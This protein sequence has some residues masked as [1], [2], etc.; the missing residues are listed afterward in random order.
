M[1]ENEGGEV[2]RERFGAKPYR[3]GQYGIGLY[4]SGSTIRIEVVYNYCSVKSID[5]LQTMVPKDGSG[6]IH[7]SLNTVC[8]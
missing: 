1:E 2:S 6:G 8:T 7:P 3:I 5:Y 4:S